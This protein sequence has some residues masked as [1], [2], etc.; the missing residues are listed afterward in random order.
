MINGYVA[1]LS[2]LSDLQQ[3][4]DTAMIMR[5]QCNL[6]AGLN[7]S[8]WRAADIEMALFGWAAGNDP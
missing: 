8:Q 6:P 7:A 3:Q 1:F 5:P 2:Y 4:L